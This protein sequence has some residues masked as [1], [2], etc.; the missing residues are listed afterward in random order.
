MRHGFIAKLIKKE[1]DMKFVLKPRCL[2]RLVLASSLVAGVVA[3]SSAQDVPQWVPGEPYPRELLK[4]FP[5]HDYDL[6][7]GKMTSP[8]VERVEFT[9]QLK[10]D[11]ARGEKIAINVRWG[12]CIGCHSLPNHEGG[13]IGP[14]LKGYGHREMPLDYTYQRIWDVRFYNPNAFMPVYGPNKVLTDQ[15]IQDVM[16]FIYTK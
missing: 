10:G 11:A 16:A 3:S 13:T 7:C 5:C 9:G 1:T 4:N 6:P 12:N 8:P 15:D 14:S 2:S